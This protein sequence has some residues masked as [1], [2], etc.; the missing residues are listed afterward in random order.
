MKYRF[1]TNAIHGGEVDLGTGSVTVPIFQTSTYRLDHPGTDHAY[2]YSRASNPT[3]AALEAALSTIEDANWA[4]AYASGMAAT[5]AVT[6]LLDP[7]DHLVLSD[8]V[9]GGTYQYVVDELSRYGIEHRFVDTSDI[10]AV[11]DGCT[12]RTRMLWVETPSNPLLKIS[13]V[14][15]LAAE[16][17]GRGAM[18]VVD[19]TFASPCLQRPLNLG[20]DIVVHSTTKY[21]GGHSDLLGGA[22]LGRES[23]TGER[24]RLR[25]AISGS[26][27]GPM[28]CFLTLRGIRTLP[29]RMERHCANARKVAEFLETH[30]SVGEVRYPGLAN[31]PG[32]EVAS[33]QMSDY[34]GIVSFRV[35]GGP[36]AAR[37]FVE[38]TNLF[39]LAVSLGSVE[40]LCEIPAL[41]THAVV[42]EGAA[43]TDPALVRLSVGLEHVDD[44]ID[45]LGQA[46]DKTG[47][48]SP[49]A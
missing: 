34:G 21:L 40:S 13:A 5:V 29:V 20:A 25:Q 33:K 23:G 36:D 46:L 27:P 7:G 26:V 24:L 30:P 15:Q 1:E 10:G 31:H 47:C 38:A 45:D 32:H 4:V 43:S 8:D 3:R 35:K 12:E 49:D 28:D 19:N 17:H 22:A 42:E 6:S 39:A 9:Y 16:A 18:L 44:L 11:R 37:A 48:E 2:V 14:E 41:M